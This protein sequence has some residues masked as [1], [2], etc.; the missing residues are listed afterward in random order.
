MTVDNPTSAVLLVRGGGS[1]SRPAAGRVVWSGRAGSCTWFVL[2]CVVGGSLER[3]CPF[4]RASVSVGAGA[5]GSSAPR[6]RRSL[7]LQ[8]RGAL[9]PL[10][11]TPTQRHTLRQ[12]SNSSSPTTCG[13]ALP[14]LRRAHVPSRTPHRPRLVRSHTAA[15][16]DSQSTRHVAGHRQVTMMRAHS[17]EVLT[18]PSLSVASCPVSPS[19]SFPPPLSFSSSGVPSVCGVLGV[20]VAPAQHTHVRPQSCQCAHALERPSALRMVCSGAMTRVVSCWSLPPPHRP[21]SFLA[22]CLM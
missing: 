5:A 2:D 14:V 17:N 10:H 16:A 4:G 12:T 21:S 6:A 13:S 15:P 19:S 7:A 18:S 9:P 1:V 22:L 3:C 20:G 8:P 11:T